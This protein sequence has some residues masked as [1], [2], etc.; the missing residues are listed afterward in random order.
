MVFGGID[1]AEEDVAGVEVEMEERI[2]VGEGVEMGFDGGFFGKGEG[3]SGI[4]V[5]GEFGFDRGEGGLVG[6]GD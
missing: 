3:G 4:N 2:A 1:G 6:L 5:G